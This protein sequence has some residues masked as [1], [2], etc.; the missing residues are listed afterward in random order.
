MASTRARIILAALPMFLGGCGAYLHNS[1]LET[2]TT[3]V[4][5]DFNAL[6]APAFMAAQRTELTAFAARED[7]AAGELL[8]ARRNAI[9][10]AIIRPSPLTE[11]TDR[12]TLKGQ[13]TEEIKKL[14]GG[15]VTGDRKTTLFN[16]S[17]T[18]AMSRRDAATREATL[19]A[20]AKVYL[21]YFADNPP[22]AVDG[23]PAEPLPVDCAK[24]PAVTFPPPPAST[25]SP[26]PPPITDKL[27]IRYY[28][29]QL[30]CAK[31]LIDTK[32]GPAIK[33]LLAFIDTTATGGDIK[34]V[35]SEL[36]LARDKRRT[37]DTEGKAVQARIKL[38]VK[39]AKDAGPNDIAKVRMAIEA[40]G[41]ELKEN[42][43]PAVRE[44]GLKELADLLEDAAAI[45][46]KPGEIEAENGFAKAR[47]A[48]AL[49]LFYASGALF[50]GYST[51][52]DITRGNA[53]LIGL[54]RVRYDLAVA[55][56]EVARQD[57]RITLL[58]AQLN[59][60]LARAYH[61]VRA[62]HLLEKYPVSLADGLADLGS[63]ADI[64]ARLAASEALSEYVAAWDEGEIPYQLLR[65]RLIQADRLNALDRA[66]TADRSY[67]AIVKP[68]IDELANYG[69]GGIKPDTIVNLLGQLG[70]AAA[71]LG[72]GK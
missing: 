71:I 10:L 29:I 65:Y 36:N 28:Q 8:L 14:A 35:S 26:P 41:K 34:A 69:K 32:T 12:I 42:A 52:P 21:D 11:K 16:A 23:I 53:A 44:A 54:E 60:L 57:R 59:A 4:Q 49:G 5:T 30:A 48:T 70:I 27:G 55:Q 6:E 51:K 66:A 67:R 72:D 19:K 33:E 62:D 64:D 2:A 18:I 39:A 45:A 7:R 50:E 58:E 22:E 13:I 63:I 61:L 40:L 47:T 17:D 37:A 3:K 24:V 68:A 46:L 38:L 1:E 20:V 15:S 25:P 56:L 9:L 31:I 43:A